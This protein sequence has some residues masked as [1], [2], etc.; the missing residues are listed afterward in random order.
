M[1]IPISLGI[2]ALFVRSC[3]DVVSGAGSGYFDSFT[4][5]IFFLLLARLFQQ[6]SFDT[7]DFNRSYKSFFPLSVNIR[8]GESLRS[9]PLAKLREGD[10]IVVRNG[11]LIPAD[12]ELLDETACI[13]Y[14]FVSG[15]SKPVSITRG[16][17]A[18]AGGRLSG[19]ASEFSVLTDVSHSYLTQLWNNE[20]FQKPKKSLLIDVSHLFARYF[21]LIVI[22]T[23]V[24]TA[25]IWLPNA[26]TALETFTAVL[27][28]ACPC[29]LTLAAPY[30]FGSA[31]GILG[32]LN[33][34]L[35]N[36]DVVRTT[37]RRCMLVLA[38]RHIPRVGR[39]ATILLGTSG[40]PI[41][42]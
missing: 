6:K 4:G 12:A 23:A 14:S 32:A 38:I 13:D 11:E 2:S 31:T 40:V 3:Y 33:I 8:L 39:Y 28:V 22:V 41:G 30:I 9:I 21:T 27:I 7:L 17:R 5:L 37:H 24:V 36:G 25:L 10:R 1:D 19:A 18:L 26:A 20:I 35:K 42:Q 15:E 16:S 29:A 34:F